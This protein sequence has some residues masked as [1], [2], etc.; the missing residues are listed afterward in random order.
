MGIRADVTALTMEEVGPMAV[1]DASLLALEGVFKGG[2][3]EGGV[4]GS[5][6]GEVT[7]EERQKTHDK[8]KRKRKG[9]KGHGNSGKGRGRVVGG[10]VD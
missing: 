10:R 4:E 7:H 8:V 6:A 3:G 5:A 2:E 1:S 9:G